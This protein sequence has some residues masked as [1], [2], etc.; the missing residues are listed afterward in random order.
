MLNQQKQAPVFRHVVSYSSGAED[1]ASLTPGYHKGSQEWLGDTKW[2]PQL[3]V[4]PGGQ[5][6][7]AL[8]P[9][10][11]AVLHTGSWRLTAVPGGGQRWVSDLPGQHA[12]L[13]TIC[14]AISCPS[15]YEFT[16]WPDS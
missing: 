5:A 6:A 2:V 12:P 16:S 10:P 9:R 15:C 4:T 7:A 11:C 13:H 8:S 1:V 3:E 14:L